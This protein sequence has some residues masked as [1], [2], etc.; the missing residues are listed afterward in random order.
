MA[1][2]SKKFTGFLGKNEWREDLDDAE[3]DFLGKSEAFEHYQTS[4]KTL[5]IDEFKAKC[6]VHQDFYNDF[7]DDYN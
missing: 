4:Y 5:K 2:F 1:Y 7:A 3:L 6:V